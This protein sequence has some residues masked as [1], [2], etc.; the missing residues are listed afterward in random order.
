[1]DRVLKEKEIISAKQYAQ[2]EGL[3]GLRE[4]EL[5]EAQDQLQILLAGSRREEI[6]ATKAELGSLQ[7]QERFLNGQLNL[8]TILSPI[9]GTITTRKLHEKI[10]QR[11]VSK[12]NCP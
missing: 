11:I 7:A 1:M 2:S 9:S 5:Q 8:L 3:V 10:G 6:D 12:F 4:K